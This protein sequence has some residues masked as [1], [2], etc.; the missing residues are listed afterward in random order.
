MNEKIKEV[1]EAIPHR[2]PFLWVDEVVE[3]LENGIVMKTRIKPE[4]AIL[5]GHYPGNPI[6]PGVI[7]CEMVFQAAAVYMSKRLQLEGKLHPGMTP[8]LAR[9]VEA[10]FKQI[11]KPG[12]ELLIYANYDK[13]MGG[14]YFMDGSI[15]RNG[16][17]VMTVKYAQA[18]VEE[19]KG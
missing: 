5:K 17:V 14:F 6:V 9:I 1:Y 18:L 2:P 7:L 8:V 16:A 19:K 10:K 4:E 15:K 11:V 3:V 13:A 12:D